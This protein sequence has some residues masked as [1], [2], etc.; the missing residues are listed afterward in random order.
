MKLSR[1]MIGKLLASLLTLLLVI[2]A[3]WAFTEYRRWTRAPLPLT[4]P[5][6]VYV[7]PGTAV[8]TLA[9]DLAARGIL[10]HARDLAWLARLHDAA[11][12]IQAGEYRLEPGLT[13][14]GLLDKLVSGTVLLHSLRIIEG[15]TFA[16]LWAQIQADPNLSHTLG[17]QPPADLMSRLG[18]ADMLPE[19]WFLPETYHFPRG[20]N[21]LDLLRRTHQAMQ[22]YLQQAW[23]ERA[24]D[25]PLDTPY[26]AL[27]LAS[28]IEKETAVPD[29]RQQIAGVFVRRLQRGMRLQ[30]DPTVI[31][32]LGQNFDGNL[33][34]EDLLRDTPWN[35]YTRSGLPKT[36]IALPG[37]NS[38]H[39]ALH[40]AE[41][42]A[43]YFVAKGDGSHY[44]SA[45]L[46]EHNQAVRRFQLHRGK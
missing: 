10:P 1:H 29:E 38:I 18:Q 24:P 46:E 30:T 42:D 33:R 40:P 5:I 45:T 19:G 35:T 44:F 8:Q 15:S 36:P 37:K 20:A 14:A 11:G 7:A 21:D 41:G 23:A 13:A 2:V 17:E 4:E 25:L 43:L 27:I 39:A 12:A 34:R 31:Y 22:D 16:E 32:G 9:A 26:E 6:T 28:I 3:A